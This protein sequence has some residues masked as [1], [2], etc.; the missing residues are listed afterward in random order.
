MKKLTRFYKQILFNFRDKI[1]LDELVLNK[2][3]SLNE[4]FNYFG[5]D[6][7]TEIFDPYINSSK[8]IKGHGFAKFYEKKLNKYRS[9]EF[10]ILEIGTWEGASTAS[11]HKFFL[12]SKLF[13]IDK[14]FRFKFKSKRVEF[15]NCN[16]NNKE[17]LDLFEKKFRNKKFTIIIDDGSHFLKD[18]ITSLKF[19]LKYLNSSG[20]FIFEDFNAP[21][22]FKEL[23]NSNGKELLFD[24]ILRK[25]KKKETFKSEILSTADQRFLFK[26]IRKVETYKGDTK[27]SD[28]AFLSK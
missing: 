3:Y 4:F 22:Y 6:K 21:K 27:I 23:E 2:D 20:I 1:N 9:K 24:E 19:F 26:N 11:F 8:K 25:I 7:G 14:N 10:S 17:N 13:A 5:T 16:I 28:I 15:I 12:K 18:M